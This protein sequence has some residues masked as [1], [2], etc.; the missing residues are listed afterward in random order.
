MTNKKIQE[1][2]DF[3]Y[4]SN[5][6]TDVPLRIAIIMGS[7]SASDLNK[8]QFIELLKILNKSNNLKKDLEDFLR[9]MEYEE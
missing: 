8:I 9:D 6:T 5:K 1:L 7:Y 3:F 4:S 2:A